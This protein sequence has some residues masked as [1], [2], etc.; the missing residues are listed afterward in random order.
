MGTNNGFRDKERCS[1]HGDGDRS[2]TSCCT[3]SAWSCKHGLQCS[4]H[5]DGRGSRLRHGLQLLVR[6]CAWQQRPFEF[7]RDSLQYGFVSTEQTPAKDPSLCI[8]SKHSTVWLEYVKRSSTSRVVTR[9]VARV[10]PIQWLP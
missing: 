10:R 2:D 1:Y 6:I 4:W 8:C 7:A 9:V 5:G 3:D